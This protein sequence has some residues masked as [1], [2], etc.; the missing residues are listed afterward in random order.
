M[1]IAN[2]ATLSDEDWDKFI[3][4]NIQ[5]VNPSCKIR[6]KASILSSTS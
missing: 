2:L 3:D 1:V 4:Y 6:R 5:D